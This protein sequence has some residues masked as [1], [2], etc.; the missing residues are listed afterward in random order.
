MTTR[1]TF[2][3]AIVATAV[4]AAAAAAAAAPGAAAQQ[5]A[6]YQFAWANERGSDIVYVSNGVA[7]VRSSSD[8]DALRERWSRALTR[9][10]VE[11]GDLSNRAVGTP[12]GI[13]YRSSGDADDARYQFINAERNRGST[14]R[15]ISW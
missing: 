11:L 3:L 5:S 13:T 6:E 8:R 7:P 9:Q 2:L 15:V 10:G 1:K 4:A 12:G 14:V